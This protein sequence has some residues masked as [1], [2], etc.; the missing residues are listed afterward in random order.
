MFIELHLIQ[1]FAPSNLNRDDTNNPK[2]CEFGGVRRAR[3]SSQC[4]KRSIRNNPVFEKCTEIP[5]SKR[6]ANIVK[7]LSEELTTREMNSDDA[8]EIAKA[9]A[10][11]YSS[12][13]AAMDNNS[14]KVLLFLGRIE[15]T[16]IAE[17]LYQIGNQPDQIKRFAEK[18]AKDTKARPSAPDIAMFG[19]MLADRPETNIDAACQVAHAISTHRVYMDT[20]FFTAIEDFPDG[21]NLGAAMMGIVGFNSACFYR[22]ACLDFDQLLINLRGDAVVARNTVE[23]FLRASVYAIPTGKQ[24]SF[25]AQNMPSFLMAVIREDGLCWSLA[26]AFEK[27]VRNNSDRGLIQASIEALDAYWGRLTAF[28]G[29]APKVVTAAL[30]DKAPISYLKESLVVSFDQWVADTIH[31]LPQE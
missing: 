6:T 31:S 16:E 18:Y 12:K 5:V 9:F 2:D 20:D 17:N 22:Y 21:G 19:R 11:N 29:A 23:A 1:N 15:I 4:L 3:I 30:E 26:N 27:P 8:Q 25:A 13:K 7:A 14:T 10:A 24:N 28:Y